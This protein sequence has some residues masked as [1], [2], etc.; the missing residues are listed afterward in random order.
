MSSEFRMP[1]LG[2]DMESGTLVEWRVKVGDTIHRGD[3]IALVET[4]K[5]IIDVEVFTSGVVEKLLVPPDTHVPVGT[6]LALLSGDAPDAVPVAAIEPQPATGVVETPRA[7]STIAAAVPAGERRKVSPAARLRARAL[8][9]DVSSIAGTGPGKVVTLEDVV[10]H[11]AV[12]PGSTMPESRAAST[13]PHDMRNVIAHA[14]SRAKREIPHYYLTSTCSLL[15]ARAWLDA[16]NASVPIEQRL[17]PAAL[18]L[19]AVAL[20]A[21]AFP[22]FNGFYEDEQFKS[23]AAV[24]VG[25]AIAMRGGR[26]VAPAILEADR[27]PLATVMSELRDLTTR[28]RSG[29]MRGSE[30][31]LPSITVTSLADEGV[32]L[33]VPVIYPPQVAMV[34]F[35]S[36]VERP[37]LVD[38]EVRA[39][40]VVT[41]SLA[42]DHR[43]TD[44]R[45]GARFIST[46]RDYLQAPQ[47]L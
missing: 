47:T 37:W 18:F 36:I 7:V 5:G 15:T 46:I 33:I 12:L 6:V 2:P 31:A 19:K 38:G 22:D 13:Q 32:D 43:V 30:L 21:R 3:V 34:G 28:V 10:K 1:S 9:L 40:P 44:G 39:A 35:G 45:A 42:A 17:L 4:D 24:N 11:A 23:A 26:L 14:M 27:K 41:L 29:H 8:G 16:H 20:A 25:M